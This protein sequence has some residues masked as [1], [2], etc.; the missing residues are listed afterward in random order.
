MAIVANPFNE[1]G[2]GSSNTTTENQGSKFAYF[3]GGA[4]SST[5]QDITTQSDQGV[6]QG[7]IL[8]KLFLINN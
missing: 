6:A 2:D 3:S 5:A 8:L 4:S 1:S 7:I